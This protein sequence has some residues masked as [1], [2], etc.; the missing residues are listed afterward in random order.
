V[1]P[2]P[3]V[4]E[5]DHAQ[6]RTERLERIWQI[7]AAIRAELPADMTSDHGWLYDDETGLPR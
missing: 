5:A 1:N 2:A 6:R 4:P 3:E 7:A